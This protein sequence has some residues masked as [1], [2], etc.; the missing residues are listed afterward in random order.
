VGSRFRSRGE[1]PDASKSWLIIIR[2]VVDYTPLFINKSPSISSKFWRTQLI[3]AFLEV[4][5][6]TKNF[7]D[8]GHFSWAPQ[9]SLFRHFY[10]MYSDGNK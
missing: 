6:D 4:T 9:P 2:C 8:D 10:E 5:D 1:K 3:D 7:F